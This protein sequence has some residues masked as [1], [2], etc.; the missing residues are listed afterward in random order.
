[1][2]KSINL[3]NNIDWGS[4]KVKPKLWLKNHPK[5]DQVPCPNP[6]LIQVRS[7]TPTGVKS[8]LFLGG[9]RVG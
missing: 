1:M 3:G 8:T 2:Q 6:V 7:F 5:R 9:W 4:I